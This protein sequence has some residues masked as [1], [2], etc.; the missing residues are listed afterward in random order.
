MSLA[1]MGN[2]A[3]APPNRTANMS[4]VIVARMS[5]EVQTNRAPANSDASDSGSPRG[6]KGRGRV[7]ATSTAQPSVAAAEAK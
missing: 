2:S 7:K 3:T 6:G 1:K 4:S 5:G